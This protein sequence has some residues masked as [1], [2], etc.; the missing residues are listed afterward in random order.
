MLSRFK[1]IRPLLALFVATPVAADWDPEQEAIE[2]AERAEAERTRQE[3]ERETQRL[4]DAMKAESERVQLQARRDHLGAAADGKSDSEVSALYDAKIKSDTAEAYRAA[5]Q[6]RNA[7]QSPEGAAAIK[8][9][10][11]KTLEQLENMTDEEAEAL[12]RELEQKYGQ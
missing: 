2:E 12:A 4:H 6:A 9:V 7:L 8:Q 1:L 10:T 5:E 11:G 3:N